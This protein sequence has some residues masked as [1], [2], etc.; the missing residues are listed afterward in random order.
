M[1]YKRHLF[2]CAFVV[3]FLLSSQYFHSLL[4]QLSSLLFVVSWACVFFTGFLK[5]TYGVL[6]G[7][8]R[9]PTLDPENPGIK[10]SLPSKQVQYLQQCQI[11][12]CQNVL[13][14]F[15]IL[16]S[17]HSERW[18]NGQHCYLSRLRP[19]F[20]SPQERTKMWHN[21]PFLTKIR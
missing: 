13:L 15:K 18:C 3:F 1:A 4:N 6:W 10:Y 9:R 16:Q 12:K 20:N 2:K 14:Y 21:F 11:S 19:G 17:T 8:T 7:I 5:N